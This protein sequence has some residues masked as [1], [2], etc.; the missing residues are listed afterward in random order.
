MIDRNEMEERIK[1]IVTE[2]LGKEES[3]GED[4]IDLVAA[5]VTAYIYESEPDPNDEE[6]QAEVKEPERVE[7][8]S[9]CELRAGCPRVVPAEGPLTAQI[10]IVG[11]GPG[12]VES[13]TGRPFI[14]KA[15]QLLDRIL[16]SVDLKREEIY[17]TNVMKCQLPGNKTPGV[18]EVAA[19]LPWLKQ[20]IETVNP[21]IILCLG[22]VAANALIHPRFRI[23]KE[24][25]QWFSDDNGRMMVATYHPAYLLRLKEGTPEERSA[26]REVWSDMQELVKR[27]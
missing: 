18:R 19:C 20:E 21:K 7:E 5:L 23:T 12:D 24:R 9:R 17:I 11:E 26:K 10:M 4:S 1:N 22:S 8:C 2:A 13:E 15:G 3:V 6:E 25:G 14:G 16:S 27:T